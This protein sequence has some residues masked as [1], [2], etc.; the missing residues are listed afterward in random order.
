MNPQKTE[1][2][3]YKKILLS[4][5]KRRKGATVADISAS[6]ALPLSSVR[7]LL[8]KAADEYRG[9]LEVTDS[10]EILYSFPHGFSSRYR[11]FAAGLRRFA[12]KFAEFA[13]IAGTFLFKIW[14]MVMLIGYF[15]LFMAI[16]LA[17]VLL[18]VVAQSRNSG[19]GRRSSVHFGL[20]PFSLIWRL[21]FYSELTRPY[22]SY[23][24]AAIPAKTKRPM[25]KAIFSFVF[26]E[27][28]PNRGWAEQE[29][30]AVI[31]YIQANRGVISL[32]EYMAFCGKNSMEAEESLL[33]FC[34]HFGGSPEA[35]EDGTIVY[36]FDELMMRSD[37]QS[38]AELSPPIQ[39]LKQFSGNSKSMNTWFIIINA[40]NLVFGSYFLYNSLTTGLLVSDAQYQA[41]S[42]IYAL[43]QILAYHIT[44]N[45]MFILTVVLGIIPLVFSVLFWLIPALR[46]FSETRENENIKLG[47]FKRLG[48]N[49][50]WSGPL[51]VEAGGIN[52]NTAECRPK[53]IA[54]AWD[55]VIKEMGVISNPGV[56]I[57]SDGKTYY[58][59]KELE[60][61]KKALDQYRTGI[62]P[63]RNRLGNTVFD[64]GA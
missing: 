1:N 9:R 55:R 8:P 64:S 53:N 57:T 13:G 12:N 42:Y 21:W 7:E 61:E 23:R 19:S 16:A 50:I 17:G 54:G 60:R 41:A 15:V 10:G 26:G 44:A 47:N 30:K 46:R 2:E 31:A 5:K 48:F 49:K 22:N 34:A 36:R 38:F 45:P 25:H 51:N 3:A 43:T 40:V 59:F 52:V 29:H 24:G 27:S 20:S 37:K 32:P 28:D 56:E 14:I 6:T 63:E 39:R 11:G 18:T 33:A 35:T 58:S 4:L 62:D